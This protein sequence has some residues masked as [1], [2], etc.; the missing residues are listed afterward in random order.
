MGGQTGSEYF[1]ESSG[2]CPE[3][4][5]RWAADEQSDL[6]FSAND[7]AALFSGVVY[8]NSGEALDDTAPNDAT[9]ASVEVAGLELEPSGES[10]IGSHPDS[11][12]STE[13][14]TYLEFPARVRLH[15]DDSG[16][17]AWFD[18]TVRAAVPTHAVAFGVATQLPEHLA[19]ALT[20]DE[21][22]RLTLEHYFEVTQGWLQVV[23][24]EGTVLRP[25]G[26]LHPVD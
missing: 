4:L 21:T 25:L 22:A 16:L 17:D 20:T 7:V 14:L 19:A 12:A 13:C 23:D 11:S 9:T 10:N 8:L 3:P 18:V 2:P 5:D 26:A 1:E 24:S 15:S 6:G